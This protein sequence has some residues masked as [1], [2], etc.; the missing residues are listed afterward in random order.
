MNVD[1][2]LFREII[3]G[4]ATAR[5][6]YRVPPFQRAYSWGVRECAGLLD[7]IDAAANNH[8]MGAIICV[9]SSGGAAMPE[10]HRVFD[11]IDGQQRLSTL[12]ILLLALYRQLN[13][14]DKALLDPFTTDRLEE[15]LRAI[16]NKLLLRAPR[17]ERS[18]PPPNSWQEEDLHLILRL[19]PGEQKDNLADYR[20]LFEIVGL[21]KESP[22]PG[23]FGNRRMGRAFDFFAGRV[24]ARSPED[25]LSL[26]ESVDN[27]LFVFISV[28]SQA[29]AF[30]LFETLN[31]RGVPLLA[32]D[33]VKNQML[34][35]MEKHH[36]AKARDSFRRWKKLLDGIP[37]ERDQE[38]F[39]RH[40]Y[41][42]YR[43]DP[44]IEVKGVPRAIRSRVIDIYQTLI[45]RDAQ[46]LFGR[47]ESAAARYAHLLAPAEGKTSF[48]PA[49]EQ[50]LIAMESLGASPVHQL[51]L[52]LT[53][54]D[55][56]AWASP[57][58]F[59]DCVEL[60]HRF[61]VRR[62]VTNTPAAN[63]LDT[64]HIQTVAACQAAVTAG[65]RL[66]LEFF[67]DQVLTSGRAATHRQWSEGLRGPLY[68][69]NRDA[70]RY[71]LIQLDRLHQT[72]EYAPDLCARQKSRF[73]WTIEHVLP[74]KKRISEEWIQTLGVGTREDAARVQAAQV[75]RLGNLTL[76]GYNS[77]LSTA[78]F[79]KKQALAENQAALG[80]QINIGYR[81]RLALNELSF[82]VDRQT[83]S[84]A[85]AKAWT[86]AHI[87]A[88][89]DAMSKLL[90]DRFFIEGLDPAPETPA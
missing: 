23:F 1:K 72:R 76:S 43:W 47:L 82:E 26:A 16:R 64:A 6:H 88:R 15:S 90:L 86:A 35:R 50:K 8:F 44:T 59:P 31:N 51:L 89:T 40:F 83:V 17:A 53:G 24:A 55:A 68:A 36:G 58:T 18:H 71:L 27:L 46:T 56:S 34:A 85:T 63:D 4:E 10:A 78:S 80:H 54:L 42:A 11:L 70:T 57:E 62:A 38:R 60:L 67:R 48:P 9:D 28:D 61:Y 33:I 75:H 21:S 22:R 19:E 87:E 52:Y 81:N 84:L 29:D 3:S 41:N 32:M 14:T 37:E 12:S 49:V 73:L 45:G 25:L 39:L 2:K 7:D 20:H 66:S 69:I 74:Q 5:A 79:A 30:T 77:R 13:A 65:T